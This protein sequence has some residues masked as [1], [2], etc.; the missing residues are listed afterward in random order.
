MSDRP[1]S[2]AAGRYLYCLVE[3]ADTT[4]PTLAV[5]GIGGATVSLVTHAGITAVVH[6]REQLYDT[7]EAAQIRSWLVS[8]QRV[9]DAAGSA[10]GTPLPFQFDVILEADDD[11]LIEWIRDHEA[12]IREAFD[13]LGGA[14]EYR[15]HVTWDRPT[16]E[17][18][19]TS[20]DD[21]LEAIERQ[22]DASGDG[23]EFLLEKQYTNRLRELL[24]ER[25]AALEE[26][27]VDGVSQVA[28]EVVRHES[29]P[30]VE[31]IGGGGGGGMDG[32]GD[33]NGG[34]DD[35]GSG[36]RDQGQD[37]DTAWVAR[38]AVLAPQSKEDAIG[39]E[40]EEVASKPGVNVE[41]T[42][43]WPPYSFAPS[44]TEES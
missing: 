9:I 26:G 30:Q 41:F 42:G 12:E 4:E 43:P 35:D 40:L 32:N 17:S 13:A 14:W 21:R 16:I 38:L 29:T 6:P 25:R 33:G 19:I 5:E 7:D 28:R 34:G 24:A 36:D 39:A 15:A 10:F 11:G 2:T 20:E 44:F 31:A 1:A 8:H 23:T 37:Q 18:A 27:L 22:R 3:T